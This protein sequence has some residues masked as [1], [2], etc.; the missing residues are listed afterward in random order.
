MTLAFVFLMTNCST[1]PSTQD[2]NQPATNAPNTA[3]TNQ[4]VTENQPAPTTLSPT[5]T[6]KAL[7]AA[8][9]KK[10]TT[11]IK[12]YLSRGTLNML[13]QSAAE[14][15]MTVDELLTGEDAIGASEP[16]ILGEKIEGET[17]IVQIENTVMKQPIELPFVRENGVWKLAMDVFMK[18][19]E[20]E[21]E[22]A[23]K[24]SAAESNK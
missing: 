23:M 7:N 5:E 11:I 8:T 13:E 1:A 9:V 16:K 21:A 6:L 2:E 12:T 22:A 17:A 15:Q 10:D 4:A 24:E 3:Q 14:Q 19:L 20:A 18:K